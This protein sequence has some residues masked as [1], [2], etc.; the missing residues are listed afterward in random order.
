[1][2]IT[3]NENTDKN[4]LFDSIFIETHSELT[5]LN[6][7]F[8]ELYKRYN[9]NENDDELLVNEEE[10]FIENQTSN[11]NIIEQVDSFESDCFTHQEIAL[12][13]Q[14]YQTNLIQ[15]FIEHDEKKD[16]MSVQD[17]QAFL[18]KI[19]QT[20]CCQKKCFSTSINYGEALK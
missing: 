19:Q 4:V 11:D 8:N 3:M 15:H 5:T 17:N 20:V 10:F 2:L 9:T 16:Q 14:I 7:E 1:Y 6:D 18:T 12:F 13:H